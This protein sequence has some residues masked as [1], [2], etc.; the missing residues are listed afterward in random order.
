[1]EQVIE[2]GSEVGKGKEGV[3]IG[4]GIEFGIREKGIRSWRRENGILEK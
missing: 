3:E 1:M 4:I 2:K